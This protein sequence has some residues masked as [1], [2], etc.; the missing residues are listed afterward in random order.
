[1]ARDIFDLAV[2]FY[3]G[4]NLVGLTSGPPYSLTWSNVGR[5][6]YTLSA[7][8]FNS[9]GASATS[10]AVQ[11]S[12]DPCYPA[13]DVMLVKDRSGSM[14]NNNKFNDAR[15]ACT[16]F[17]VQAL[18]P[19]ADQGGWCRSIRTRWWSIR[20]RATRMRCSLR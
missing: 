19:S 2:G 13:V 16:N 5:G 10:A 20:W 7:R 3:S 6:R 15:Q 4:G 8:A 14:D 11:I 12:I 9:N 1:M 17:I 18:N